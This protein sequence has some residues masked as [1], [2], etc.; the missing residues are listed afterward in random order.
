M[1]AETCFEEIKSTRYIF[2]NAKAFYYMYRKI[3]LSMT[4]K[5]NDKVQDKKYV[6][7]VRHYKPRLIYF[8]P[9]FSF[10]AVYNQEQLILR[11]NLCSKQGNSSNTS[12]VYNV[13]AKL[14]F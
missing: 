3:D 7:Y 14:C 13:Q 11:D 4:L 10:T 1:K 5:K 6:P 2:E 8:L 12:A 9:H